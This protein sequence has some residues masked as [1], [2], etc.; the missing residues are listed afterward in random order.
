[1]VE[2]LDLGYEHEWRA[3]ITNTFSANGLKI[4]GNEFV[5]MLSGSGHPIEF[6]EERSVAL[7]FR[8][9]F[10][11][12]V[13]RSTFDKFRFGSPYPIFSAS[14]RL[15]SYSVAQTD[16]SY[17]RVDLGV[18]YDLLLPPIGVS[19]IVLRGGKIFGQVPYP[20]LKLHEANGTYIYDPF[21]FSCMNY[22]EFASDRWLTLFWEHHFNGWLFGRLPLLKNTRWREVL[23]C[24]SA[25]G[26]LSDRNLGNL[27][28]AL[29]R[30]PEGMESLNKPYVE[31]GVGVENIW[32]LI[33]VDFI[34][35]MTH[36]DHQSVDKIERFAT[37]ISLQLKF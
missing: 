12:N 27:E 23:I 4:Y 14:A 30:S 10:R 24:K 16:K 9:S 28:S 37:N 2:R 31:L 33:R 8:L 11:E 6:I 36:R 13:V 20:L 18:D 25:W 15:G 26:A 32:R 7:G 1:M 21:A 35:R 17:F 5:P 19:E 3:G 29:V 22:Y 34:W